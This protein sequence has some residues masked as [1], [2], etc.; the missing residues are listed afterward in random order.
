MIKAHPFLGVGPEQVGPQFESYVPSDVPRP[1]PHGYYGHLH[2][3]YYH[4]AAERGVPALL[5]LLWLLGRAFYDFVR[6]LRGSLDS[7]CRWVLYAALAVLIAVM[8]SGYEEVNLG[9]SEVLAMFLAV[10]ACGYVAVMETVEARLKPH[11]G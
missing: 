3:I 9:D 1:L 11:A 2:N 10:V 7:E 8:L 6:T 5:A 4:Y